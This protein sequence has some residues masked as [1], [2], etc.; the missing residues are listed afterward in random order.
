MIIGVTL[1][2]IININTFLDDMNYFN[3]KYFEDHEHEKWCYKYEYRD[4]YWEYYD[5][6][7]YID[8]P[9]VLYDN[10]FEASL[11][12]GYDFDFFVSQFLIVFFG[13]EIIVTIILLII[14]FTKSKNKR[15]K[16]AVNKTTNILD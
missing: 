9:A 13:F 5:D 7:R 1:A 15:E 2:T 6:E 8:C 16:E 10:G 14:K 4:S 11:H 12:L 3:D